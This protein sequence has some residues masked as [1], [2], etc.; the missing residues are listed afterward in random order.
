MAKTSMGIEENTAAVLCYVIGWITGIVFL[1]L[2]KENSFV[3]FHAWQSILT[4]LPLSIV[5]W[6]LGYI[7]FVGWILA[8]LIWILMIILWLVLMFKAY[9]GEWYKIPFAGDIADRET[10]N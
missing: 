2:E 3:R 9:R 4:F 1:I 5:A 8:A 7:P 10:R 6:V